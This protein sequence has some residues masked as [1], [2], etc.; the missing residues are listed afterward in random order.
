MSQGKIILG[1]LRVSNRTITFEN[2]QSL[3][4]VDSNLMS[5]MAYVPLILISNR[6]DGNKR[7]KSLWM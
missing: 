5:R 1:V 7:P 2:N 6:N 3:V 4:E